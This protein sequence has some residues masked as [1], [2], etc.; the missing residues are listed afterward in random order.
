[1]PAGA[2]TKQFPGSI[3]VC[4]SKGIILEMNDRSAKT[5]ARDGGSA[6]VGRSLLDCHP[7]PARAK[8]KQI[9]K[10]QLS[11]CYTIEKNGVKKLIYQAPWYEGERF[12]GLVELAIE[13]PAEIPHFIR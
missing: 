13:L 4:D 9:M 7:E 11:N 3:T 8:L 6:L 12:M 10:E 2:W 5:F 1:M